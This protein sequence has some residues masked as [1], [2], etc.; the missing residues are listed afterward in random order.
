M[1]PLKLCLL[2]AVL[3]IFQD[4]ISQNKRKTKDHSNSH[5]SSFNI[6]GNNPDV[7]SGFWTAKT[8]DDYVYIHFSD[9]S[10]NRNNGFTIGY[11]FPKEAFNTIDMTGDSFQLIREAGTVTFMGQFNGSRG[12]GEYKFDRNEDFEDFLRKEGV[13]NDAKGSK[14]YYFFKLFLGDANRNYVQGLI[15]EGYQPTLKELGKMSVLGVTLNY[16]K[17]IAKT[18]YKGLELDMLVKFYIHGV[19]RDYID[20]LAAL[21]YGD[22]DANMVKKFAIHSISTDYVGGL[23]DAGYANLVPNMLKN[24]AIH[25]VSVDYINELNKAGYKN[26]DPNMI[27]NFAIH[28]VS[29]KF[30]NELNDMGYKNL[31]PNTIKNF[32]I[33]SV[34][35]N[36][37]KSLI[38]TN[39]NRPTTSELK[40]AKIHGVSANFIER[41]MKKGHNTKD[42]SDYIK[43]KIHGI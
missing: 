26:L 7:S 6:N 15:S 29:S 41:A 27:K 38:D 18:N 9:S 37:I 21:G 19:S 34:N 22:M 11:S 25:S 24:F 31:D 12:T 5:Y 1:K 20:D 3:F 14:D 23:N 43:L 33:H 16:V 39:I 10:R 2:L 8:E 42:L 40:K 36:Y 30:I 17:S 28:S 4:A 35:A 13:D 32:A